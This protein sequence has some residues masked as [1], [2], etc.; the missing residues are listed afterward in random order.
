[1]RLS[2]EFRDEERG[3]NVARIVRH[4]GDIYIETE[5]N[6][7]GVVVF[8]SVRVSRGKLL[9]GLKSVGGIL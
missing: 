8:T 4:D 1:M 5:G 2:F 9:E 7:D 3:R 6:H